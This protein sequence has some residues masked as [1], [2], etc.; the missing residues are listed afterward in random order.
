MNVFM[1]IVLGFHAVSGFTPL[2]IPQRFL[3]RKTLLARPQ[4]MLA[5]RRKAVRYSVP[6]MSGR[7]ELTHSRENNTIDEE[8]RAQQY[9]SQ[10]LRESRRSLPRTIE[11]VELTPWFVMVFCTITYANAAL[12]SII[13][14]QLL[15]EVC[16]PITPVQCDA[17]TPLGI[18]YGLLGGTIL[19]QVEMWRRT[20]SEPSDE[21]LG[22]MTGRQA[23][24]DELLEKGVLLGVA[25]VSIFARILQQD[26]AIGETSVSIV[27]EECTD[28][29]KAILQIMGSLSSCLLVQGLV[30]RALLTDFSSL[31]GLSAISSMPSDP[32]EYARVMQL[33]TLVASGTALAPVAAVLATASF[34][35]LAY[36]LVC[37]VL[38]PMANYEAQACQE[39]VSIKRK[40]YAQLLAF[41]G[42]SREVASL[43][44]EAFDKV[45]MD[46]E[47]QQQECTKRR[48]ITNFVRVLTAAT[49]YAASGGSILAPVLTN[50]AVTD[51][52]LRVLSGKTL[53]R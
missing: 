1:L 41:Q 9:L 35:F 48:E 32:S 23:R 36:L 8:V 16:F 2:S 7:D 34:E 31:A 26:P 22:E 24:N 11:S 14:G 12:V 43:R 33:M 20:C 46:W 50:I 4:P 45:A 6:R 49:V 38:L 19:R 21:D 30:E 44:A 52:V 47:E 5:D 29:Q 51:S 42:V 53:S 15:P 13:L 25:P 10:L 18:A 17:S 39:A 27:S 40:R 37:Q 3:K 28:S